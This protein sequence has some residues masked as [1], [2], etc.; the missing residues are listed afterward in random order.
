MKTSNIF[1]AFLSFHLNEGIKYF[2]FVTTVLKQKKK[3]KT[4]RINGN[5]KSNIYLSDVA[6]KVTIWNFFNHIY[7]STGLFSHSEFKEIQITIP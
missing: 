3:K 2:L 6:S 4:N 5:V 1:Q 7:V